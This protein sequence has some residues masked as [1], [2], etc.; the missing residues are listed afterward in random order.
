MAY[1]AIMKARLLVREKIAYS[2]TELVEMVVWQ[3]PKPVPP[4]LHDF[5]YRLA[6]IVQGERVLGYD[7]ERGKGDHKHLRGIESELEFVSI[8]SVLDRFVTEVEMLRRGR[9]SP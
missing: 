2:A 7:N 6:Y 3:V 8:D 9:L 1:H 4:S 5:K